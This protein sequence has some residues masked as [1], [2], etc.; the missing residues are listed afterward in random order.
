MKLPLHCDFRLFTLIG[1]V[2]LFFIFTNCKENNSKDTEDKENEI[3][4]LVE[5]DAN[6]ENGGEPW[7]LNIEEATVANGNY[8]IEQWT[9]K[10]MQMVLMSVKPGEEIDLEIHEGHDQFIRIEQG[11][12]RILMGKTEDDLSFDETVTDDWA[13]FIPAGY[14]HNVKNTGQEDL[15][16]YTIYAPK[17]HQRGTVHRTYEEARNAHGEEH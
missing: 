17:E 6:D 14:Y 5:T 4:D 16:V 3:V 15:K 13:I 10:H 8:R 9:G 7:V 2:L 11:E 12:A 1:V